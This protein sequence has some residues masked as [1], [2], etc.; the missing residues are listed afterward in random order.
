M[1]TSGKQTG[2]KEGGGHVPSDG[3]ILEF[4]EENVESVESEEL[5]GILQP[6]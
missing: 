3:N 4:S 1:I 2:I 5:S 6:D